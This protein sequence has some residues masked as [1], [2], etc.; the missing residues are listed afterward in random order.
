MNNREL[1]IKIISNEFAKWQVQ[2]EN[3]N[4]L[5][6]YDAN[7]F[8]EHTLCELLNLVFDYKLINA[9]LLQ[10]NFPAVDLV[11]AK[12]KVAIQVTSTKTR[13]KIQSTLNMFIENKLYLKYDEL[14]III[15]SAKQKSYSALSV[16]NDFSFDVSEH[17]LDFKS[18]LKIIAKLPMN[19]IEKIAAL[20]DHENIKSPARKRT[21]NITAIK[22]KLSLKK[23]IQKDFIMKIDKKDW[24]RLR[25]EPYWQF[26]YHNVII[27]SV[28]DKSWP[29]V[30]EAKDTPMSS[31]FKGEFYNLYENGIELIT[32]GG[33]VL[34]DKEGN[35][36]L[37]NWPKDKRENNHAY[38]KQYCHAFLRIP[39]VY[40]VDYDM[41]P[42]EYYS[43]PT[44][45]VEYAKDG[46]PYEEIK[47]GRAGHY[48]EK[49]PANSRYSYQL[50]NGL[51]KKLK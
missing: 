8:S 19:R 16:S 5:N 17:I 29:N 25:Y 22:K 2:I 50:D 10:S 43:L 6:L 26:V 11:D 1:K 35:W 30:D 20:L 24:N 37:M 13:D 28:D 4:S 38:S 31:W 48:D 36:D 27:R 14:L 39:Y 40:I 3:L 12:N 44:I 34:V 18:L 47:Y 15:L 21:N 46:T 41:D 42:D 7:I 33:Y 23:K 9:N 45:Y 51:R 49:N 32:H